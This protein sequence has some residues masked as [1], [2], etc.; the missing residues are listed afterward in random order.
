MASEYTTRIRLE[1]QGDG[2][3]ANTWGL[4]LN[5]NVIDLVDEAIA[6]Y[7]DIS[8]AGGTEV[9]LTAQQATTD[10]S[11]NFGLR[12]TG[13]L[14]ADTTVVIPAQ[15]KIYFIN[16]NT[17]GGYNVFIKT[18]IGSAVTVVGS[19]RSMM[20]ATNGTSITT[21]KELD[22][23]VLATKDELSATSATLEARV[24]TASAAASVALARAVAVS[25]LIPSLSATLETRING[26]SSTL[27]STSATLNSRI[28]T[29]SV[30][31]SVALARAITVSGTLETRIATVSSTFAN[32]SATLDAR[33]NTAS[34][35]ASVALA[36]AVAVSSTLA[37]S[38]A[39]VSASLKSQI[40]A[41]SATMAAS[42]AD[43]R[44]SVKFATSANQLGGF[45]SSQFLRS[46][47]TDSKTSGALTFSPN[48]SLV[49]SDDMI[50]YSSG[51][52]TF[53]MNMVL[54]S[55]AI[56]NNSGSNKY[57][58]SN[59]GN[60]TASGEVTAYS[61]QRLKD[62]IKTLDGN[63]AFDMRGVSFVK[64]GKEG[65]GVIAQEL[66]QIAP[67]LV[68]N[69]G[70]YKS[71]AYGNVVGYL[72]EAVKLLKKEIDELKGNK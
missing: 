44:T 49:F 35:A 46:D 3:N 30:A 41:L 13:T 64:D 14:T 67:E 63:K 22:E 53:N 45:T 68:N 28:D 55:I 47:T 7:E 57:T 21:F 15:E 65:S 9:S 34:A 37:T 48:V 66:E 20:L 56:K 27:A 24:N 38:I 1:K 54:S 51:G 61:D 25:A 33:I 4:R 31:A 40:T 12:F 18:E 10:Q 26:V 52:T 50:M 70:E 59:D 29:A 16:N 23:T 32:T 71:V 39:T 11:R 42:I 19:G 5:T 2:E 6:G 36:R 8:L 60:F 72:I 43:V 69:S 17:N 62:K 58:F